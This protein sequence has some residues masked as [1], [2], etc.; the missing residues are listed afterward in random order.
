M[1][2]K[3]GYSLGTSRELIKFAGIFAST[4]FVPGNN[5]NYLRIGPGAYALRD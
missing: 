2:K 1:G 5:I 3:K 4:N